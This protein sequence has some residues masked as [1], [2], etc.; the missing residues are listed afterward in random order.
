MPY[1]SAFDPSICSGCG[2][3]ISGLWCKCQ[4]AAMR[5]QLRPRIVTRRVVLC[6]SSSG[7]M[8]RSPSVRPS[9]ALFARFLPPLLPGRSYA[10]TRVHVGAFHARDAHA[11]TL[12][13]LS[14]KS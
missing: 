2:R 13:P 5:F 4:R 9:C 10:R 8:F 12:G 1:L 3:A 6:W 7:V 14:H 11:S